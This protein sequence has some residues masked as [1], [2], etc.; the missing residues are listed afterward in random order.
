[1][2]GSA[3]P[4]SSAMVHLGGLETNKVRMARVALR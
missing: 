2:T 3:L 1:M 4:F